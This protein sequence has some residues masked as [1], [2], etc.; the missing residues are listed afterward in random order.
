MIEK[1][2]RD[3]LDKFLAEALQGIDTEQW[4]AT[5][6]AALKTFFIKNPQ[7]YRSYGPYWWLIKKAFIDS[8]DITF[9]QDLDEK[10]VEALGY[11]DPIY[12]LAASIFYED[13]RF[14]YVNALDAHHQMADDTGEAVEFIS[15]DDDMESRLTSA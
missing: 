10:W 6:L 15:S 12:D 11:N 2:G 8:G 3:D 1:P 9:G 4:R 14:D 13:A 5:V 7:R